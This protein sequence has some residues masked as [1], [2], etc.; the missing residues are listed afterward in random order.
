MA[1]INKS[2]KRIP[3][4]THFGKNLKF[5][6]RM[7]GLSQAELA[8]SLNMTRNNVASYESGI[9]E[10]NMK[11]FLATCIFFNVDPKEMLES[12]LSVRP[13]EVS[14]NSNMP[15]SPVDKYVVDQ[16]DQFVVQTNEM[17]KILEGYKTFYEMRKDSSEF[18]HK[19]ELYAIMDDLL[20]LLNALI[21]SNWGFIQSVYPSEESDH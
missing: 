3:K 10:P 20:E 2:V 11:K 15:S 9:V 8:S 1:K 14:L 16:L 13:T 7:K 5:L 4:P 19:K 21:I 17:T 12:I 6:R 18:A